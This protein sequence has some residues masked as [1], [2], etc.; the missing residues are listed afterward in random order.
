MNAAG[1]YIALIRAWLDQHGQEAIKIR[2]T[3]ETKK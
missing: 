1:I 3:E 2:I